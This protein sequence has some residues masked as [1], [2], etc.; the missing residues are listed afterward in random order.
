MSFIE[1][2]ISIFIL[3]IISAVLFVSLSTNNDIK[4]DIIDKEY[5]YEISVNTTESIVKYIEEQYIDSYNTEENINYMINNE[6]NNYEYEG[7]DINIYLIKEEIEGTNTYYLKS[8]VTSN[9]TKE[10]YVF[11]KTIPEVLIYD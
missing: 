4:K 8:S 1:I 10:T 2:V 7:Y 5:A 9:K 11:Y 6:L 3:S